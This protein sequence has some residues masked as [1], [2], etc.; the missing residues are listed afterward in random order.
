MSDDGDCHIANNYMRL[1]SNVELNVSA[2][3]LVTTSWCHTG[4]HDFRVRSPII[5]I[6]SRV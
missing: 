6:Y 5:I 1:F 4:G 3:F 2:Y